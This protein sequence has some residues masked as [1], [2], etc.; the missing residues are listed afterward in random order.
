MVRRW[1]PREEEARCV[2]VEVPTRGAE[3]S[4]QISICWP[5]GAGQD[6]E[7]DGSKMTGF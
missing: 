7:S 2:A 3:A 6:C 1:L 5:P 4:P